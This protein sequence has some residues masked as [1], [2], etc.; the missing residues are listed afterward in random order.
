MRFLV[1]GTAGFIGFHVAQRLLL[2]GHTVVG[3]DGMTAY[4]DVALKRKRHRM[5]RE[6]QGFTEQEFM[7][8]DADALDILFR[9]V[10]PQK[11]VHLAAQA[12]VRYSLENP[13]AYIDANLIGTFNVLEA[14]RHHPVDHLLIASTSSAYGGN[15]TF[16]FRETDR[17]AAPL[18]LYAASK[19]GTEVMAHA[20]AHLWTLPTTVFRFFTVYGPWGRPDMALFKFTKAMHADQPIE[21]YNHG[22][23]RRDFTYI[24]DLVESILRLTEVIPAGPGMGAA[25]VPGDTLSPVAPYRIV[26][27]GGGQPVHLMRFV[28]AIEAALG[29]RATR[30]YLPL[31]A[32]D[33]PETVAGTDLLHSLIGYVPSTP[34]EAGVASFVAWYRDFY[35]EQESERLAGCLAAA[36]GPAYEGV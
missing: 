4:Y 28:E 34:I 13:R 22:R 19:I 17:T 6:F 20:Y 12:G 24:D 27:I 16:P 33:V 15:G 35:G 1:T 9:T 2:A 32:G 18:T 8:E 11:V 14:C 10:Q 7:L 36:S 26:N 23:S 31:P 29:R 5:L 21:I 30:H 3:L 25:T